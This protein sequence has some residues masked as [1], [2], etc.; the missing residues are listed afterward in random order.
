MANKVLTPK[1]PTN[2]IVKNTVKII[3]DSVAAIEKENDVIS[4]A[5]KEVFINELAFVKNEIKSVTDAYDEIVIDEHNFNQ[6]KKDMSDLANKGLTV[7]D[8]YNQELIKAKKEKNTMIVT[9]VL[10]GI[11]SL[12]ALGIVGLKTRIK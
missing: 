6:F 3:D 1:F 4:A 12:T 7:C 10:S 2:E 8:K 9:I 5:R 11:A